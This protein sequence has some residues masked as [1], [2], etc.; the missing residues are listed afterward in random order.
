MADPIS[1]YALGRLIDD[2][3]TILEAVDAKVLTHNLDPSAHGQENESVYEHRANEILDHVED[4]IKALH[5]DKSLS[6]I[7]QK[8]K[9][10]EQTVAIYPGWTDITDLLFTFNA[11]KEGK[12]LITTIIYAK[13]RGQGEDLYIR[14]RNFKASYSYYFPSQQGWLMPEIRYLSNNQFVLATFTWTTEVFAGVNLIRVQGSTD[15]SDAGN[16]IQ[17]ENLFAQSMLLI[18]TYGSEIEET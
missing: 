16:I 15:A 12:I 5:V 7:T 13:S 6:C 3:E 2:P 11:S 17:G 18:Q 14:I 10:H 9:D 4:S 8:I 1:W